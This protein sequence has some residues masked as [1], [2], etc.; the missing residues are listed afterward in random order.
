MGKQLW[1]AVG[2]GC[3]ILGGIVIGLDAAR[4]DPAQLPPDQLSYIGPVAG[5]TA[6]LLIL[7]VM[8][9]VGAATIDFLETWRVQ[10]VLDRLLEQAQGGDPVEPRHFVEAFGGGALGTSARRYGFTLRREVVGDDLGQFIG[11]DASGFFS[12][13]ALVDDRL[14]LN[15][16]RRLPMVLVLL[17]LVALTFGLSRLLTDYGR[18]VPAAVLA[19]DG[20]LTLQACAIPLLAALI[21]GC[22]LPV[23]VAVRRRQLAGLVHRTD[24]LFQGGDERFY[25]RRLLEAQ[26]IGAAD[27][28]RSL[29]LAL[30]EIKKVL[31]SLRRRIDEPTVAVSAGGGVTMDR[32][33]KASLGEFSKAIGRL[34]EQQEEAIGRVV[35][36]ALGGFTNELDR[37]FSVQTEQL[38]GILR[39]TEATASG[40]ERSLAVL[41]QNPA[42]LGAHLDISTA[43]AELRF[44]QVLELLQTIAERLG[45]PGA[46]LV[47]SGEPRGVADDPGA[48][49][50][51]AARL[52]GVGDAIAAQ[53][54]DS[55]AVVATMKQLY[56]T[57]DSL[58][59]SVAPVL[60]RLVDTQDDLLAALSAE[61]TA[62]RALTEVAQD[63]SQLARANRETVE[64]HVRL[65]SELNKASQSL[66]AMAAA[67]QSR[68]GG[69][70][71]GSTDSVMRALRELKLEADEAARRLPS[72]DAAE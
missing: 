6:G 69:P 24:E 48:G 30:S 66:E 29:S 39:S 63:L 26:T 27:L 56:T 8:V 2:V 41:G 1:L 43:T 9:F 54:A 53:A 59:L 57:V 67:L 61:T 71:E 22:I 19:A 44:N 18:G 68:S 50:W 45:K 37:I 7:F 40:F 33:L 12:T 35:H 10:R 47:L 52:E 65:A 16:F 25:I 64:H 32:A 20:Q 14:F 23:V 31:E 4:L 5:L 42:E 34:S 60:N 62:G 58:C 36:H 13:E 15:A 3:A 17:A 70:P 49:E 55:R 46:G 51:L 21:V 38:Q 72:L 28:R 11:G